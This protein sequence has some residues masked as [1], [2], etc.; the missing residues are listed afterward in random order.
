MNND[1]AHQIGQ[2]LIESHPTL[3]HFFE[4]IGAF[5]TACL[6]FLGTFG[7]EFA[8]IFDPSTWTMQTIASLFSIP[9]ALMYFLAKH[10]ER[11]LLKKQLQI[12]E[13]QNGDN[14]R[15]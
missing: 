11:R 14:N 4:R 9:A 7:G 13:A 6:V 8:R 5:V 3:G 15:A 10:T 1:I 12:L 2:T